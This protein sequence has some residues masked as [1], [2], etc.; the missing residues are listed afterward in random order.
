MTP[1]E[2]FSAFFENRKVTPGDVVLFFAG[3]D[4]NRVSWVTQLYTEGYAPRIALVSNDRRYE[5]GSRPAGELKEKLIAQ[6]VPE[7]SICWEE[8][9]LNTKEE[10]E[11][12]V[13]LAAEHGWSTLLIVTSPHH[14]YRAF[15]TLLR[16]MRRADKEYTLVPATAPIPLRQDLLAQ[17]FERIERYQIQGD[18]ASFEEGI[19]YLS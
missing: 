5:Y 2:Q 18:A 6:G 9:A 14:Q 15:L 12:F 1:Q 3:D 8:T 17:E 19:D 4:V 11:R 7:E 16:A 13:A 10:A